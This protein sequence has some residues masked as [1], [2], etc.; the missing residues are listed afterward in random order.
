M[1]QAPGKPQPNRVLTDNRR[2]RHEYNFEEIFEA[3]LVLL[4]SEVKSL[5]AGNANL[6]EAWVRL[7]PD[8]AVL[9]GCHIAPY[10]EANRNNHEPMRPRRLLLN[11]HELLKLKR[12]IQ[13]RGFTVIPVKIYLKGSRIKLEIALAKGK[14]LHD[15]RESIKQRDARREMDRA[16]RER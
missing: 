5:R 9:V 3:G 11:R 14:Q 1:G 10:S 6:S 15:K 8:G 2:A 16:R 7:D 13:Q 4:G 12:G